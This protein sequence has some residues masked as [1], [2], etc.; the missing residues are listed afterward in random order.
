MAERLT[1]ARYLRLSLR[2]RIMLFFALLAVGAIAAMIVG[3]WTAITQSDY[4]HVW[5]VPGLFAS[6]VQGWLFAGF[7]ILVLVG[8]IWHVFDTQFV[9]G[10]ERLATTI[11]THAHVDVQDD[12]AA[13]QVSSRFLGDL[14]PATAELR[15]SLAQTRSAL[16]DSVARE[17][18]RLS[19]EKALLETL[20]ADV[21]VAVLL[22]TGDF[23][24]VFYNGQA[25]AI[26]GAASAPGLD[27]NLLDYLRPGPV[28][29][30]YE[31]LSQLD[32]PEASS[33]LICTTLASGRLLSGRM[34]VL[35]RTDTNHRPGFVLTLRDVTSELATHSAREAL[36]A[37]VFERVRGPAAALQT[38][39]NL[40]PEGGDLAQMPELK[41][42][43]LSE[44]RV[45]GAAISDLGQRHEERR[46]D[47]HPLTQ[48]RARDL[49]DGI[50]AQFATLG[51]DLDIDAPDLMLY[52]DAFE[53]ALLF[54]WLGQRLSSAG[55]VRHFTLRLTEEDGPGVMLDLLW[56]GPAP[57]AGEFERW[58]GECIDADLPEL[59]AQAVL[60]AHGTKARTESRANGMSALRLPIPYA[61]RAT[62]RP[63]PVTR[64]VVYDFE[65]LSKERNAGVLDSRLEDLT[66]VVFDT[67]TTGL[68]PATDEIVQLAAVRI[69]NG[70][71]LRGEVFDTLVDPQ[72]PI[73]QVSTDVHGITDDM[74]KG[75]PTIIEAGRRF[76][77]F[78]R[79]A[80]L[81]AHNAPFDMEFL[82]R[83]EPG[84]QVSFDH[85]VLD[86]LLLSRV[87]FGRSE[88]HSLDALTA[89]LGINMTEE[90]RHTAIGDTIATANA[91]LK[92]IPMLKA[93]GFETFGDVLTEMR[94]HGNLLHAALQEKSSSSEAPSARKD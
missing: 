35:P 22:C 82:R 14:G 63:A 8:G 20:I 58:L 31:R 24:L 74:V 26:L 49:M 43:I 68:F 1:G 89:R 81:V 11:R 48:V 29:H 56:K 84:M 70:R 18:S 69:V 36:L 53:L 38:A 62:R 94:R 65:L 88:L 4:V 46:L 91:F 25:D 32:D 6:K 39:A 83:H 87:A 66:Y 47:W 2:L 59:T 10:L 85:P 75:A 45:L 37:E 54:R 33:E 9:R 28:R 90:E 93:R 15:R 67:E 5:E 7:L 40:M 57:P 42:A 12:F 13:E 3:A 64:E 78:A 60:Y 92:L 19:S 27:R 34:R 52:C 30:A 21:P 77:D 44:I 80:V 16:A 76:H 73:P 71:R 50:S 72:R 51:I 23:Q 55:Q 17:T 41:S 79:G 86:T 61:R